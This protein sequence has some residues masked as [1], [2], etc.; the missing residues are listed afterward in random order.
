MPK[1]IRVTPPSR[2]KYPLE[3]MEVGD[4]FFV[5]NK[6]KNT[7]TTH[8]S[9]EGKKLG[10]KYTTR[11]CHMRKTQRGWSICDATHEDAVLGI[12]VWRQE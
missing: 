1:A 2:R 3:D 12:G 5:P 7:L 6:T 4:M 9:A 11:L 10:R 8:I